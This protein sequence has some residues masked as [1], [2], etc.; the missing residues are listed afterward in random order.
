[1]KGTHPLYVT[2][3]KKILSTNLIFEASIFCGKRTSDSTGRALVGKTKEY[4]EVPAD[5]DADEGKAGG[6]KEEDGKGGDAN[7]EDGENEDEDKEAEAKGVEEDWRGSW[8]M[9][10]V[11]TRASK[12]P[13]CEVGNKTD[14]RLI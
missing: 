5:D 10:G 9:S 4:E 1:M 14:T 2:E 8:D 6:R 7:E 11:D 13:A 3:T 12:C